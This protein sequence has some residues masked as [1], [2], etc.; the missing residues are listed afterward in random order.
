MAKT[1]P[2]KIV[3]KDNGSFIQVEEL[4]A[5]GAIS[6]GDILKRLSTGNDVKR[7]DAAATKLV[8]LIA[9]PKVN[10]GLDDDYEDNDVNV[11]ACKIQSGF[12]Y[13]VSVAAGADAIAKGAA[14]KTVNDG[15]VETG[16][17]NADA[18]FI[19][20]EAVDNSS[21]TTKTRIRVEAI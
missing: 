18:L 8:S 5:D 17:V 3:L 4:V 19:A 15:T 16:G 14:L 20:L 6:P 7:N 12:E 13:F 11:V 9:L 2:S 10:K 21:G 1:N